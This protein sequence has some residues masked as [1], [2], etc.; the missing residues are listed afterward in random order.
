LT[1]N[2]TQFPALCVSNNIQLLHSLAYYPESNCAAESAMDTIK[3]S[4]RKVT[5][6]C[7]EIVEYWLKRAVIKSILQYRFITTTKNQITPADVIFKFSPRTK[8][9]MLLPGDKVKEGYQ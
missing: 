2:S 7:D 5:C 8:L 6:Q 3:G 1:C 9:P 4:L